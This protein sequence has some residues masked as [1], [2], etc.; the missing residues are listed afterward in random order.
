MP[1]VRSAPI[2]AA[3]A[4]ALTSPV[5]ASVSMNGCNASTRVRSPA[6]AGVYLPN[7]SKDIRS[8][9]DHL[10]APATS[11]WAGEQAQRECA[12]EFKKMLT[13]VNLPFLPCVIRTK[14]HAYSAP[15][16]PS[17]L[18]CTAWAI[19][20]TSIAASSLRSALFIRARIAAIL[21]ARFIRVKSVA[22]LQRPASVR[23]HNRHRR[24]RYHTWLSLILLQ[25][26]SVDLTS[27]SVW[28]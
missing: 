6:C 13:L 23:Y 1:F 20:V 5:M 4:A 22:N 15:E 12:N 21:S 11:D 9:W 19:L 14:T 26:L 16:V 17:M 3:F 28:F 24:P 2:L 27:R 10:A 8:A 7:E 25:P 18:L